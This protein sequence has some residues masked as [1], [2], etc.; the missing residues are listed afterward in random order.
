MW[1]D[2]NADCR[3]LTDQER[4]ET[5]LLLSAELS[6]L[7][8]DEEDTTTTSTH[9]AYDRLLVSSALS[10]LVEE[11]GVYQYDKSLELTGELTRAVSDHYPVWLRF[12]PAGLLSG[13]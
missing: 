9:C 11:Y 2:L 4:A 3:Y 1:G 8:S 12:S 5:A 13:P 7:I 10:A 6:S